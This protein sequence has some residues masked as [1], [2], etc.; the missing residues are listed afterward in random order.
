MKRF[1]LF[2]VLFILYNI[3]KARIK[4]FICFDVLKLVETLINLSVR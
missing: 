3:L 4:G 2:S 1:A